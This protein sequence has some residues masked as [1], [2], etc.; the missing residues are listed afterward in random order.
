MKEPPIEVSILI[1]SQIF[2]RGVEQVV[3]ELA[4]DDVLVHQHSVAEATAAMAAGRI[5]IL[6]LDTELAP[7]LERA[8]SEQENPPKIVLISEWRHAGTNL[9][10]EEDLP[11]GFFPARAPESRLKYYLSLMIDCERRNLSEGGCRDCPLPHSLKPRHLLL[12]RRE[13]EVFR[14]LGSLQ[15][16][17]EISD[18]LNVSPKTI[19]AHCANIKRKLNVNNSRE[20]LH[21]AINWVEGR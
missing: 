6:V 12:T 17:Q 18:L 3:V 15:T 8:L 10:V 5:N 4:R 13:S 21:A 14:L 19:E 9:P 7:Q 1:N 11:C 16:N 2:A 20:L